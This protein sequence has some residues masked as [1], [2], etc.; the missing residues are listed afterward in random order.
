MASQLMGFLDLPK[1]IRLIIYEY[2]LLEIRRAPIYVSAI[3]EDF[4]HRFYPAAE[5]PTDDFDNAVA[6][7]NVPAV[8]HPT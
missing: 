6:L 2:L 7:N 5:N 8:A 3:D 1:D 4:I